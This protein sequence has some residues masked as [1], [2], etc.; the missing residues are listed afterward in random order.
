VNVSRMDWP[1]RRGAAV[2]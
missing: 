1:Y 2:C